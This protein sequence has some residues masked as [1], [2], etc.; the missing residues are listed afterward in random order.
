MAAKRRRLKGLIRRLTHRLWQLTRNNPTIASFDAHIL[1]LSR[2][3]TSIVGAALGGVEINGYRYLLY[4]ELLDY[5]RNIAVLLR[6]GFQSNTPV[7]LLRGMYEGLADIR[8]LT[9]DEHALQHMKL[10]YSS[11]R[12]KMLAR[13]RNGNEFLQVFV[14]ANLNDENVTLDVMEALIGE[15]GIS[16]GSMCANATIDIIL[17]ETGDV[18]GAEI[19]RVTAYVFTTS[20]AVVSVDIDTAD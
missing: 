10:K 2:E 4:L 3:A 19:I 16:E 6:R 15:A 7:L 17:A 13:A 8:N 1:T 5:A 20:D 11:E 12:V 18:I 9:N 14:D